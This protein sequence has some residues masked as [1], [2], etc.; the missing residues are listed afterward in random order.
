MAKILPV[1]S[2]GEYF[3]GFASE[4]GKHYRTESQEMDPVL[5]HVRYLDQKTN[6]APKRGNPNDWRYQG[7]IP[8]TILTDWLR[9]RSLTMDVW[10]RDEDN[11]KS[12]FMAYLRSEHPHFLAHKKKLIVPG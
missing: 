1:R 4:G 12:K 11:I 6:S 5:A 10:A 2:V 7:S 3:R 8:L 9:R